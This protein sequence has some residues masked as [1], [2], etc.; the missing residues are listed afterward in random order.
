MI[1]KVRRTIEK[2]GLL[3]R[4]DRVVA[5]VSG[6]PDSV[7]LLAV[8]KDLFIPYGLILKVAHLNHGL[9][10]RESDREEIFVR[11]LCKSMDIP[12]FSRKADI[13][14][15]R[16]ASRG[17]LEE[18]C[19]QERYR[20]FEEVRARVGFNKI[21]LGHHLDDQAET[22]MM[23]ILRGSG[24]EG[25]KGMVPFRDRVFIR[26]LIEVTRKEITGFLEKRGMTA[27]TDSSNAS[28]FC[29]RNRIRRGLMPELK[30]RYNPRLAEN[31]GRMADIL[32][33]EDDWMQKT[34]EGV[35]KEW[36]LDEE[37]EVTTLPVPGLR[38]LHEALRHRIVKTVLSDLSPAP[39]RVGYRHVEAVMKLL[40][41]DAPGATL[42]M[43]FRIRVR[44]EYDRLYFERKG[45]LP[46]A[47]SG[48]AAR[49]FRFDVSVPGEV[50]IAEIGTRLSFQ[51]VDTSQVAPNSDQT[52]FMDAD[53][54]AFP[55]TLRSWNPGDRIQPLGMAGTQKVQDLFINEK[56]PRA[57][58]ED[59]LL[60]A[61]RESVLWIP[62]IRLSE[63]V[64]VKKDTK[65]VLKIEMY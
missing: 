32:R 61:D 65:K 22:V 57:K 45:D 43:P 11:D 52:V 19:R 49:A 39:N 51:L 44:R 62:G 53:A 12:F 21:A 26:P 16:R 18:I 5:A 38:H 9:R 10:G 23:R 36:G 35:L 31:L 29:L 14:A 34:V 59:I 13:P 55:L 42:D 27:M 25:L 48:K 33:M 41:G 46:A 56:V 6:G 58:R 15:A 4:G 47:P 3:D 20:F 54:I 40:A 1:H 30:E 24:P 8:L 64:R 28:D 17:T 60:L 2:Y 63:R 7:A 50:V 37:K